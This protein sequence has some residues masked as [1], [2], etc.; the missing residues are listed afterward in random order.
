MLAILFGLLSQPGATEANYARIEFGMTREQVAA[1]V[2]Q[3]RV[4]KVTDADRF[5]VAFTITSHDIRQEG[6]LWRTG[7]RKLWVVFDKDQR[8]KGKMLE[9]D[10]WEFLRKPTAGKSPR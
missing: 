4:A 7:S 10:Q 5:S 6:E 8:V 2:R 1:I 9:R 3:P